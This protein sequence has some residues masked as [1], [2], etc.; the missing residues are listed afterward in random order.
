MAEKEVVPL[1][2]LTREVLL[3][4]E[5][6]DQAVDMLSRHLL[7]APAYFIVGGVKPNEGV[8]ITRDQ[9][10]TLDF[11]RL[12]GGKIWY[13]LETNYDHWVPP[14]PNDDRRTP[15]M[16]AMNATTQANINPDTLFDVLTIQPVCNG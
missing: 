7:I 2:I 15:G 11:W 6:Y 4:A 13:I 3:K 12:D 9:H 5:T 16:K 10:E 1:S 8:V 14:P